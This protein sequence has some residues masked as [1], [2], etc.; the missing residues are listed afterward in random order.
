MLRDWVNCPICEGTD[1]RRETDE[2]GHTLIFCVNHC[3][4]SNIAKIKPPRVKPKPTSFLESLREAAITDQLEKM[5]TDPEFLAE[6]RQS[7]EE[8]GPIPENS[9]DVY[10]EALRRFDAE[11]MESNMPITTD[12]DAMDNN[13]MADLIDTIK[14]NAIQQYLDGLWGMPHLVERS[15]EIAASSNYDDGLKEAL[16]RYDAGI[17]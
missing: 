9:P 16:R 3:C 14:E 12:G 15:R 13:D 11:K 7:I 17:K 1:M 2:D 10:G 5:K 6:V 4:P 8:R